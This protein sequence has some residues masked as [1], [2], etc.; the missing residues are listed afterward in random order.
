MS[1][2]WANRQRQTNHLVR[3]IAAYVFKKA[4]IT[5]NQIYGLSKLS[6]IT[7][8]YEGEN[9][10][11]IASTKIPALENIFNKDY[12]TSSIEQISQDIAVILNDSSI[13]KMVQEHT[14]FTNFYKAYRN[15]SL[16]W[17]KSNFNTLLP[18]YK[19]AYV[20]KNN[21]DRKKLIQAIQ[22]TPGIPKAN[23]SE[24]LMKAEH[25]LT[26]AFF[27]LDKEIKFPLINGSEGV[28]NLLKALEV[29]GDDLL[30]QYTSM[31]KLYGTGR[32]ED[33][34]DLDQVGGDLPDF[35][36]TKK[37]KARKGLLNPTF[38]LFSS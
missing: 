31:V 12:K 9:A 6:W 3:R 7:N 28:K 23:H 8:S 4:A 2:D 35:I 33:A 20:A 16:L 1:L 26:P 34:A 13:A 21:S 5:P 18:M 30:T 22:K 38:A 15:S 24:Q 11:Y 37:K 25:F 14:G 17:V 32:I 36:E 29:Q 19:A 10:S 27:M